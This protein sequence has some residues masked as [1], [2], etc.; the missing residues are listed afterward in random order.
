[1]TVAWHE[2]DGL[3]V[4]KGGRQRW[5]KDIK[6]SQAGTDVSDHLP[7]EMTCNIFFKRRFIPPAAA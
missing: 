6:S 2:I 1:M 5:V 7:K 3:L 4:K